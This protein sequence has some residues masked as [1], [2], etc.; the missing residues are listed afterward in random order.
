MLLKRA[1]LTSRLHHSM[2]QDIFNVPPTYILQTHFVVLYP[3]NT[4]LPAKGSGTGKTV[5]SMLTATPE[6]C[7]NMSCLDRCARPTPTCREDLSASRVCALFASDRMLPR[8]MP[9]QSLHMRSRN[10]SKCMTFRRPLDGHTL[11][12]LIKKQ[13]DD[14]FLWHIYLSISI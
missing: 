4:H 5:C 7:L 1:L 11:I 6:A 8:V 14:D 13:E 3:M 2:L 12:T 10:K 9:H